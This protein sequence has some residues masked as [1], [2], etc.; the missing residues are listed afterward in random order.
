MVEAQQAA[1]DRAG[2]PDA[3]KPVMLSIDAGPLRARRILATMITAEQPAV[4]MSLGP[5]APV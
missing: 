2:G 5:L 1:Y 3:I 4:P